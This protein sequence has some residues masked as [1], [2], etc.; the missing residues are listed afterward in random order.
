MFELLRNATGFSI[1][2][3]DTQGSRPTAR[4]QTRRI[5]G[6]YDT[7]PDYTWSRAG[8]FISIR[9]QL[10][11]LFTPP[12]IEKPFGSGRRRPS[13]HTLRFVRLEHPD[14]LFH[15]YLLAARVALFSKRAAA[16]VLGIS[17]E[18]YLFGRLSPRLCRRHL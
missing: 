16:R 7:M 11:S 15:V 5:V 6:R 14:Q 17:E 9:N 18:L 4:D 10:P 8:A 13:L 1:G 2:L 3:I 12:P